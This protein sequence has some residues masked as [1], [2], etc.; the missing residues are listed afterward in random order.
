[1]QGIKVHEI[2]LTVGHRDKSIQANLCNKEYE[3]KQQK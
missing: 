3:E 2:K 1:M